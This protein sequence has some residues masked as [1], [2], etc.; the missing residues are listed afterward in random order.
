VLALTASV[1]VE[2]GF[3]VEL[4]RRVQASVREA[5]REA[6]AKILTGDTKVMGR[7]E[8]DGI[9]L[10]TSGLEL[11]SDLEAELGA[12]MAFARSRWDDAPS[13]VPPARTPPP[14]A[15]P[16]RTPDAPPTPTSPPAPTPTPPP[17]TPTPPAPPPGADP[18]VVA[19][20]TWLA[21]HEALVGRRYEEARTAYDELLRQWK[22]TATVKKGEER[23]RAGRRAADVGARGPAALCSEEASY[24]NGRLTAEW[25][26]E[27]DAAFRTDFDLE[28]PFAADEAVAA[29]VREGMCVLGGSSALL[30]KV[31]FD[32]TDV[33][34]EMDCWSDEPRDFG[35]LGLEEGKAYRA[36][37]FHVGNT[38]FRLKKG[39]AAK[40]LAGHVLWL[41]GDGVWRDADPGT[42]GFVRF[43]VR[44]G[45]HLKPGERFRVRAELHDG[46]MSGEIHSKSDPVDLKGPIRG[47]DG[48]SIGP[49]R[50]GPFAYKGRV[51]V[52][53]FW[54]SGK[55]DAAW[56]E[57]TMADLARADPGPD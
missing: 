48:K 36:C 3:S 54:V 50:V 5:C 35:L 45:N 24:K 26:F 39:S 49:L 40:V 42:R 32:P 37:A 30:A 46:Q 23:I 29:E 16:A 51:G 31:V 56:L 27:N 53:R 20:S 15:P 13:K 25:G 57:K 18:E 47:D 4:L 33:T 19:K 2:E 28:E 43:A 17:P 22:G 12:L 11:P 44:D 1:I 9:I 7:G 41:F 6:D 14:N 38:Q 52:E 8:V 55:I 21:A 10:S 34:W